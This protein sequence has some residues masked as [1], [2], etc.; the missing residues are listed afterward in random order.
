[1]AIISLGLRDIKIG[2]LITLATDIS[3]R[4]KENEDVFPNRPISHGDLQQTLTALEEAHREV[5]ARNFGMTAIRDARAAELK[6]MLR[7]LAGYVATVA[8]DDPLIAHKAG[9]SFRKRAEG[10]KPLE[11]VGI[12]WVRPGDRSGELKMM[13]SRKR[14]HTG[15]IVEWTDDP[16]AKSNWR[17]FGFLTDK[18]IVLNGLKPLSYAWIRVKGVGTHERHTAWSAPMGARVPG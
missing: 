14:M 3:T 6:E 15:V 5:S 10:T 4:M 16:A 8:Q 18:I 13:V 17:S 2:E 7:M 9:M 1:M 11:D 12:K